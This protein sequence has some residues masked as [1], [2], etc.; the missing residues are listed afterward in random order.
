MLRREGSPAIQDDAQAA[1]TI[2]P[3]HPLALMVVKESAK[4]KCSLELLQVHYRVDLWTVEQIVNI[5]SRQL[6][7]F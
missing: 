7:S 6:L 2:G 5:A 1:E 4:R 3:N